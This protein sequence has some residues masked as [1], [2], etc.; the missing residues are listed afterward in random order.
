M[1]QGSV[2]GNGVLCAV[3]FIDFVMGI[4]FSR[5]LSL[6]CVLTLLGYLGEGLAAPHDDIII[7]L[8]LIYVRCIAFVPLRS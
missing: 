3:L 8:L 6:H 1:L 5:D 7:L 2:Q 4:A